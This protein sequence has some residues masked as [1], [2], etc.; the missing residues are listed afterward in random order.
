MKHIHILL[1]VCVITVIAS[2]P[3]K[4]Q[5]QVEGADKI[6]IL[7]KLHLTLGDWQWWQILTRQYSHW[8]ALSTGSLGATL[9]PDRLNQA[10]PQL[11]TSCATLVM[12][13]GL[14]LGMKS[15][16]RH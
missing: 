13:S 1:L 10:L 15:Q 4:Q 7:R 8:F 16:Q 14:A 6:R 2:M 9:L 3:R 11:V 12:P 5:D